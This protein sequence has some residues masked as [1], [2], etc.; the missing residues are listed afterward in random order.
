MDSDHGPEGRAEVSASR[1]K[2]RAACK[3]Y[4]ERKR[5]RDP[6]PEPVDDGPEE[7]PYDPPDLGL[8]PCCVPAQY[9]HP[10]TVFSP[11]EIVAIRAIVQDTRIEKQRGIMDYALPIV[12]SL[13]V[14]RQLLEHK[15]QIGACISEFF[16][17][18]AQFAAQSQSS[19]TNSPKPDDGTR[20]APQLASSS[21]F[22]SQ[23]RSE[24]AVRSESDPLETRS[25][26]DTLV[27]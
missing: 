22:V 27:I 24:P 10:S 20:S 13:G 9:Y 4:Y 25:E 23:S 21:I 19:N 17:N 16:K 11:Q 5:K 18:T 2:H 6:A 3:R 7:E 8:E 15:D 14:G 1:Q 26:P 12:A